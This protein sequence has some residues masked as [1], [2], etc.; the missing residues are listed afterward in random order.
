MA[1]LQNLL[2]KLEG[3][4]AFHFRPLCSAALGTALGIAF[5]PCL[6]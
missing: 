5:L 3:I 6:I 1:F 2:N 4:Q